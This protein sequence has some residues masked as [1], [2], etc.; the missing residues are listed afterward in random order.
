MLVKVRQELRCITGDRHTAHSGMLSSWALATAAKATKEAMVKLFIFAVV[1]GIDAGIDI[2]K[3]DGVCITTV[4][5]RGRRTRGYQRLFIRRRPMR[6]PMSKQ[7]TGWHTDGLWLHTSALRHMWIL[8]SVQ[9]VEKPLE[10]LLDVVTPDEP[11][12]D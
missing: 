7:G 10:V 4:E 8:A 3:V 1:L 2:A 5:L 12:P 6:R 9:I 11:T